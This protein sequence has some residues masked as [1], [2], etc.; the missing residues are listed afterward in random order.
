MDLK[1]LFKI[2]HG[3]YVTGARDSKDRL[4]GSCVDSV[5]VVEA[6]P[7]QV[8]VS[9]NKKS[10]TC[11]SVLKN[12]YLSLSILSEDA[13]DD[14]IKRFGMQ[15]SGD[16]DKWL[17]DTYELMRELPVLK[18]SVASMVLEVQSVQETSGHFVFLCNVI[19]L[20]AGVSK[21]PLIYND[22][23]ARKEKKM[24]TTETP[25]WVCSVC[26]YVYD[27]EVPFEE[28]PEDWV[29]PLCGE[30]KSVFVKE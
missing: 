28:L 15:S 1:T 29:C 25:K 24:S 18:D 2:T 10:Y 23:Q 14:L 21:K 5:M 22:Y 11:E 20:K 17:P 6:D 13:T 4:I 16:A 19:E 12:K 30:P 27:G 9:L 8:I 3:V 7:A 26:G